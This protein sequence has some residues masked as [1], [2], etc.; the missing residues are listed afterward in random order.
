M[1]SIRDEDFIKLGE[2]VSLLAI[3]PSPQQVTKARANVMD[4]MRNIAE[5]MQQ[6]PT[7]EPRIV[8]MNESDQRISYPERFVAK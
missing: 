7:V 5:L 1:I 6:A 3:A 2:T 8:A 4:V